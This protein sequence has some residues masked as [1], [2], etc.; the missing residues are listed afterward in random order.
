MFNYRK[1]TISD[2]ES[3]WNKDI[4]QNKDDQRYLKWKQQ[5]I[6]NNKNGDCVTF[7]VLDNEDPIGQV[8]ILFSPNCSAVKN[9]PKLCNG[10]DTANMNAFRIEK[11]MKIKDISP[12]LLK[13]QKNLQD[14]KA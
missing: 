9:R 11:N 12:N 10:T 1:A 5:Y 3:I 8:T 14:P 4:E 2:L 13:W 6:E 7:V